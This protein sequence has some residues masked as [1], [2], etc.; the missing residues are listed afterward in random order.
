MP[1]AVKKAK[2]CAGCARPRRR[3]AHRIRRQEA[4]KRAI[5]DLI[6]NEIIGI[7]QQDLQETSHLGLA[8]A[9]QVKAH[10]AQAPHLLD[11]IRREQGRSA[12]R[13]G[14]LGQ[15]PQERGIGG[16]PFDKR[17]KGRLIGMGAAIGK[18]HN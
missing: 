3:P 8:H 16:Q 4:R 18:A 12:P 15:M 14:G 7:R 2:N 13:R 1:H 11:P 10:A 6:K 5:G 9:A 17:G